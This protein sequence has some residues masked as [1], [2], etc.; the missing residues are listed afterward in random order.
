MMNNINNV[1]RKTL[2]YKTPYQLFTE[3]YG[4][5]ISKKLHLKKINKDEINLG[6]KL[7]QK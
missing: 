5:Q 2:D 3:K 6:Y 4:I 7:I 1:Q